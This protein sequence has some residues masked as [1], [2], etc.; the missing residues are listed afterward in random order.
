M[1]VMSF[2]TQQK[3]R[4]YHGWASA[5]EVAGFVKLRICEG[6]APGSRKMEVGNFSDSLEPFLEIFGFLQK[7]FP[8]E[9]P[10]KP[11]NLGQKMVQNGL[12]LP[13]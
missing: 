5:D 1:M 6:A 13:F 7:F 11:T 8:K 10:P 9:N 4:I 3:C 12:K 2:T